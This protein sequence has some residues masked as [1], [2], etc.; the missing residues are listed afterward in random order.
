M[1]APN[2]DDDLRWMQRALDEAH[3]AHDAGDWPAGAVL[4][5][6]GT[7]LAAGRNLQVTLGDVTE[8]AE[9]EAIRAALAAHGPGATIGSTLYC[10]MEPCPMCAGAAKLAG[11]TRL[12]LALRHATLRRTD[13]GGYTV[14]AFGSMTGWAPRIDAGPLHDAYGALR[15]RW[16]R[17]TVAPPD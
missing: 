17:D 2:A 6:D 8:H 9:T 10:T 4:V 3:A 16:G 1:H 13:L 5:R 14:E 7:L 11:V 12:V 15:T